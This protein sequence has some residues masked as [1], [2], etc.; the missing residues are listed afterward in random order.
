MFVGVARYDL[1]LPAC[2]SLKDKRAVV[3]SL[4]A[5]LH[6]KFR[7]SV[8]EVDHQDLHQRTTIGVSIVSGEHFQARRVL[9]QV[10][11]VVAVAPGAELLEE[12][13]DVWSDKDL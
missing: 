7:C 5:T 11:R 4:I 2:R 10:G 12:W 3:R 1:H 8:A 9:Q 13:I 6:T